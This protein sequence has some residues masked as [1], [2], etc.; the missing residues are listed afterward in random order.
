M[1]LKF[2]LKVQNNFL[3][4]TLFLK[5]NHSPQKSYTQTMKYFQDG[6]DTLIAS[7]NGFAGYGIGMAIAMAGLIVTQFVPAVNVV[8]DAITGVLGRGLGPGGATALAVLII[9][10][11][12]ASSSIAR[13]FNAL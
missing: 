12:N 11:A 10:Y 1:N 6:V 13:S 4:I 2:I 7:R 9:N 3:D 5:I 8:V